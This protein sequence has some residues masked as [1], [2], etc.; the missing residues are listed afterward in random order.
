VDRYPATYTDAHG[1]ETAAI[2]NNGEMLRLSFRGIEF[3]GNDFDSLEPNRA[4][5]EQLRRFTLNQGCL[6]SCRIECRIPVPVHDRGRLL[7]GVLLVELVLGDPAPNGGL[8]REQLRIV[9]EYD[10]QRF[11]SPGTSGWFE[12]ELL[13]VQ[14]QL[15]EG[16][17]IKACIN[18]LYSDYSPSG[19][20]VFGC[21][22]CFRNLKTEY[23]KVTTK[24]EF[25]SV[26]GRQDRFVQETYLCPEFE[27]RIPGTG[28]RG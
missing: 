4:E 21:M 14:A 27:R 6:C 15:P 8:D 28:Y 18:C 25:W 12:G 26:H 20:G 11:A 2:D 9:L 24:K 19:H 16:V 22:M 1:S 7:G 10:G 5:P 23:L 3:V 13:G 17:F